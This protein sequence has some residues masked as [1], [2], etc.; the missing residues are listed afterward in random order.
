MGQERR[1][2]VLWIVVSAAVLLAASRSVGL[3]NRSFTPVEL[4]NDSRLILYLQLRPPDKDGRLAVKLVEAIKGRQPSS[5]PSLAARDAALAD[6]IDK[7]F[8]D[9]QALP[10]V[11]FFADA[12]DKGGKKMPAATAFIRISTKWYRLARKAGATSWPS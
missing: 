10:A 11:A 9:E 5:P 8:E 12:V 3:I 1:H 4:T 2:T 6:E 7:L